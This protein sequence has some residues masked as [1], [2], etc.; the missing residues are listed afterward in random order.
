MSLGIILLL[1]PVLMLLEA[2]P[3]LR[4][5]PIILR[6]PRRRT[7]SGTRRSDARL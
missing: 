7:G 6:S 2:L 3:R 1:M 4:L 5:Q